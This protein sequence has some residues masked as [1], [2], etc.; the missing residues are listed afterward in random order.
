M[1]SD[2][3]NA[4]QPKS[5]SIIIRGTNNLINQDYLIASRPPPGQTAFLNHGVQR[6]EQRMI[7]HT[8]ETI[9]ACNLHYKW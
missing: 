3:E 2:I 5:C 7:T 1:T 4:S 8:V 6:S 9:G